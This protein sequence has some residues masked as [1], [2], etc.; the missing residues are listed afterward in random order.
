[1]RACQSCGRPGKHSVEEQWLCDSCANAAV[2]R[3]LGHG[4]SA[5]VIKQ[6]GHLLLIRE[7]NSELELIE[8][9]RRDLQAL[10][11]SVGPVEGQ[12]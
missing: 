9:Y 10:P 2:C 11:E 4:D 1:M 8:Q 7:G 5:E 3:A 6:Y 12:R